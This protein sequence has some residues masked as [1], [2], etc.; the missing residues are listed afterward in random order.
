MLQHLGE[1][2]S[3]ARIG[4]SLFVSEATVKGH[5][6]RILDKLGCENRSQA[7]LLAR[8]RERDESRGRPRPKW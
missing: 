3:D 1:G 7:A 8:S 6:S 5:V 2:V 4:R